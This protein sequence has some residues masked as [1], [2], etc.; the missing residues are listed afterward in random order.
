MRN[1][2]YQNIRSRRNSVLRAKKR[3]KLM[4]SLGYI[5]EDAKFN[6]SYSKHSMACSCQMCRL[7]NQE[8]RK[9]KKKRQEA[10]AEIREIDYALEK[11]AS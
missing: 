5:G 8:S 4:K 6:M 10:I 9:E 1:S 2:S 7:G 11:Q 3:F